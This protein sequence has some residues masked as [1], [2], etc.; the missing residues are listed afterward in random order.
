MQMLL[1]WFPMFSSFV[2]Q[3]MRT[4]LL[5]PTVTYEESQ[6]GMLSEILDSLRSLTNVTAM[7]AYQILSKYSAGDDD[8]VSSL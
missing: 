8:N 2:A 7:M 6:L 5:I 4:N 3:H 1:P